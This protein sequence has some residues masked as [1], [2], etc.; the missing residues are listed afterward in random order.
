MHHSD[1]LL[2]QPL[3]Q[4]FA[5]T[6]SGP[7]LN[8][9]R[10]FAVFNRPFGATC[11]TPDDGITTKRHPGSTHRVSVRTP[12]VA[13]TWCVHLYLARG[14]WGHVSQATTLG[15]T[16]E[17]LTQPADFAVSL[18]VQPPAR[19]FVRCGQ[20]MTYR[21][22]S[23]TVCRTPIRGVVERHRRGVHRSAV[24][25]SR[26]ERADL[27]LP[28]DKPPASR[29]ERKYVSERTRLDKETPM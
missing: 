24:A 2:T 16:A 25:A 3:E 20:E 21:A 13:V 22:L 23:V 15:N 10:P 27:T 4:M 12:G 9:F 5:L 11:P 28:A 17:V 26:Y 1:D 29:K 18:D 7:M 6:R 8:R 19:R 14:G